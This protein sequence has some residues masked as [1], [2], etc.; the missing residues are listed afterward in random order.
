[1]Y[2][3]AIENILSQEQIRRCDFHTHSFFSD[4]DLLPM[5]LLRRAHVFGHQV[6]AITDHASA[7]NLDIIPKLKKDCELATKHWGIIALPGVE[8]THVPA[9]AIE[10]IAKKARDQGAIIIV[11]H[12]ETISEP[13]E[14]GTNLK[15][16]N[17]KAID[18]LA[19]PGML[20]DQEAK[21]CKKNNVLVEITSNSNH[22][23]TNGI[24][25]RVG[26]ENHADFIQNTDTHSSSNMITYDGAKK[27][28][29][30]AGL[31]EK[32]ANRTM[33][34]NIRKLLTKTLEYF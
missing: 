6:Y 34:D 12:G 24:T 23:K 31:D 33:Q 10:E 7:S 13:V 28:L 3:Q 14:P 9:D 16:A 8:L 17:S 11:L 30:A 32:E 27:V 25:A 19:H 20:S 22:S 5:E 1:M 18:I 29:I 2:K 15:G 4:G 26:L 21:L